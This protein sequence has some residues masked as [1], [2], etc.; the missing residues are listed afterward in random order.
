MAYYPATIFPPQFTGNNSVLLSG[1]SIEAYLAGTSTPTN[2]FTDSAG[3]VAGTSITLNARGEP[4]VSGNTVNIWLDSTVSYKFILKDASDNPL[5]TIDGISAQVAGGITYN[6][7]DANAV[8]RT[9]EARLQDVVSVKD[10]GAVGDGVTDDTTAIQNALDSQ[11]PVHM[12]PGVFL[13][14]STLTF[15][16][17]SKLYGS[18]AYHGLRN[19]NGEDYDSSIHTVIKASGIT[20]ANS[21][22]VR[23]S[24]KAVGTAATD[25]TPPGTDDLYGIAFEGITVDGSGTAEFGVYCY[26][27][28]DSVVRGISAESCAEYGIFVIGCFTNSFYDCTAYSN[29]KN[30]WGIGPNIFSSWSS[31]EVAVNANLFVRPVARYNGTDETYN[32]TTN[33]EEGHGFRM[34]LNRGNLFLDLVAESNDGAGLYFT[35]DSEHYGGPNKF[36][37]GYIENNQTDVVDDAR[38][39]AEYNIIFA[40][41]RTYQRHFEFDGM[42]IHPDQGIYIAGSTDPS[43]REAFLRFRNCYSST[44]ITINSGTP[45][46]RIENFSPAPT[47]SGKKP[48]LQVLSGAGAVDVTSEVTHVATDAANALSLA[49]GDEGQR[50]FIVMITDNGAGTLTPSNLG[51]GSTVTFD[52]VGDSADLLF[53]NGAWHFMGGTATLA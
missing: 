16:N 40:S 31:T 30:G 22:V 1:G 24:K 32:Q 3:T 5:Y 45:N 11:L 4:E 50:K 7:G 42:F 28:I 29:E 39:S 13:V 37:G 46:Y 48:S 25:L 38:G 35:N 47:Y 51:N 36:L 10:F 41:S 44:S 15:S 23:L 12:P 19:N 6:Q 49:D 2:M 17:G 9:V 33:A 8:N 53:T 20:G 26:R 27:I 52:D 14:T 18:G 43:D 21:C 34:E